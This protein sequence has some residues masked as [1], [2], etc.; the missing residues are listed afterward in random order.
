MREDEIRKSPQSL[1]LPKRLRGQPLQLVRALQ[2]RNKSCP[3][4]ELLRYYC[5]LD[6]CARTKWQ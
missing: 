1:K 6:V 3:Y 5:P 4:T 2:K